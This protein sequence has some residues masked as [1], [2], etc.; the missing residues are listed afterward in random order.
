MD[1]YVYVY[2]YVYIY[3]WVIGGIL[4]NVFV[5]KHEEQQTNYYII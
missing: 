5:F 1:V 4:N 3:I 2:V